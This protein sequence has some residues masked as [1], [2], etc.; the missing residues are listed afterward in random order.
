[1]T[2]DFMSWNTAAAAGSEA[3]VATAVTCSAHRHIGVQCMG[4]MRDD[5][6]QT[7]HLAVLDVVRHEL[8][9]S[10]IALDD[11][12]FVTE[13][14][15]VELT[16]ATAASKHHTQRRT[17]RSSQCIGCPCR[18]ATS[19]RMGHPDAPATWQC[20]ADDERSEERRERSGR[21]NGGLNVDVRGTAM[22]HPTCSSQRSGRAALQR[23]ATRTRRDV[24]RE[25]VRR[26]TSRRHSPSARCAHAR[27]PATTAGSWRCRRRRKHWGQHTASR[28]TRFRHP[29]E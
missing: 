27:H 9:R 24:T 18:R 26:F 6:T 23:T 1:M 4:H 21:V 10:D 16:T 25:G 13:A 2:P 29:V 5:A 7:R 14:Q 22:A 12:V 17:V 28:R 15:S 20:T 3:A 8:E 11:D 19:K